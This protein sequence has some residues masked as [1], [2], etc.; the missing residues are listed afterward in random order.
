MRLFTS[1]NKCCGS[2]SIRT[3][4][5]Y[6]NKKQLCIAGIDTDC[7]LS[8]IV[9]YV[10]RSRKAVRLH[11]HVG[12]LNTSTDEHVGWQDRS[13]RVGDEI[14]IRIANRKRADPPTKRFPRDPSK[15]LE[16]K[17]RYVRHYAKELG[18]EIRESG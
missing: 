9:D 1:A 2:A 5:A 18:W 3:F 15:E 17:K 14:G 10:S 7:V 12:G 6:L 11:L 13:L 4:E 16:S 8:T